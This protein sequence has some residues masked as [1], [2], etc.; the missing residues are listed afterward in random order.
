[1][2]MVLVVDDDKELRES[3]R[4]VLEDA[5]Y[6]ALEAASGAEALTTL[7]TSGKRLVVLLDLIMPLMD[8]I[9]VLQAVAADSTLAARHSYILLTADS[10]PLS[11]PSAALLTSLSVPMVRKPVDIDDLLA[12]VAQATARL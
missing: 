10:R 1:M 5:G 3:L 7:R 12:V 6:Y 11:A 9:E 2:T 4:M 8:G